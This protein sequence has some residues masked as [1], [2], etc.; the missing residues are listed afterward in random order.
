MRRMV[1]GAFEPKTTGQ[2]QSFR[3]GL[4]PQAAIV[5]ASLPAKLQTPAAS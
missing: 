2:M 4:M 3:R 1:E 5:G